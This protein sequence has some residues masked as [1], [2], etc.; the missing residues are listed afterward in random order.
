MNI[1][2]NGQLRVVYYDSFVS[3]FFSIRAIDFAE[4][5]PYTYGVLR[6]VLAGVVVLLALGITLVGC[7]ML[8]VGTGLVGAFGLLHSY[9]R[10]AAANSGTTQNVQWMAIIVAGLVIARRTAYLRDPEKP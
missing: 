9:W 5:Q 8:A 4:E 7:N 10:D 6:V 2:L 1:A 3:H